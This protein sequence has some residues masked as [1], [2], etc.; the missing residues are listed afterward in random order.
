MFMKNIRPFYFWNIGKSVVKYQNKYDNVVKKIS[1]I[2]CYKFGLSYT[3][4]CENIKN[5]KLFYLCFPV[6]NK[7]MNEI[8]WNHY[9]KLINIFD[10]DKRNFYFKV[11][12]YY[13]IEYG[14]FVMGLDNY[15]FER[16]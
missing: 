4:S 1:N 16:I 7:N 13:N 2:Y 11:I 5:M 14:D 8:S 12:L 3:F 10:R 9:L 15:V 6:F